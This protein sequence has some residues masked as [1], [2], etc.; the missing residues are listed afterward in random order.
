MG[1]LRSCLTGLAILRIASAGGAYADKGIDIYQVPRA[2]GADNCK[3]ITYPQKRL[4]V[5]GP[6]DID[7]WIGYGEVDGQN[8]YGLRIA[9][10]VSSQGN[11]PIQPVDSSVLGLADFPV[12]LIVDHDTPYD[13]SDL[14]VGTSDSTLGGSIVPG[15][16]GYTNP[17]HRETII[18]LPEPSGQGEGDD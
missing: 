14:V 17:N 8:I 12:I 2:P 4:V 7:T 6:E 13:N 9:P 10:G 5:C 15:T 1:I 11:D 18:K 16:T 3:M